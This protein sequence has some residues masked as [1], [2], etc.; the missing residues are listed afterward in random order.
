MTV[1]VSA[2]LIRSW[3]M[4]RDQK[5][6]TWLKK[7]DWR[8]CEIGMIARVLMKTSCPALRRA[9]HRAE[10]LQALIGL[11]S[12]LDE[13]T[14][15]KMFNRAWKEWIMSMSGQDPL[16]LELMKEEAPK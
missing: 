8:E 14:I 10:Y 6:C 12:K 9:K 2:L 13:K 5:F 1:M 3:W 16:P 7:Q 11:D 4:R 15:E